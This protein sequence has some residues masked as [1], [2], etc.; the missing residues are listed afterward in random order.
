M[1]VFRRLAW[2]FLV[3]VIIFGCIFTSISCWPCEKL[4]RH[5]PFSED[6]SFSE[7]VGD[8]DVV[9]MK[10]C[11]PVSDVLEDTGDPD[12]ESTRRSI[13]NYKAIY[14][15]LRDEFDRHPN[16]MFI[17]WTL[18][19]RHRL[20]GD[21]A[22]ARDANAARAT[23]FSEWLQTGFLTED[24]AHPNICVWDFRGIVMD[25]DTN[26][27]KYD[28]EKYH[29][30]SDS[31]PNDTA[32]NVAGPLFAQFI[33]DSIVDFADGD[34]MAERAEIVFLHHSTGE[35]VYD[36]PNLGVPDW[37]DNYNETHGTE[38]DISEKLYPR[39]G[40]MPVDYYRVW[41]AD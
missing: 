29:D 38:L 30:S 39:D 20:S 15:L 13:E 31:H 21:D 28:Y 9:I 1:R 26:F 24:G 22:T 6:A 35:N 12:P 37:F 18:P 16:T 36:Y 34:I 8:Y 2:G 3:T 11:Y 7:L 33:V 10:H 14:R 25:P 17:V 23:E 32:N 40:N 27:L 41:L 4:S 5:W 19:P